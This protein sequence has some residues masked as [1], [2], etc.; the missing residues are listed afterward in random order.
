MY[1][2]SKKTRN[3]LGEKSKQVME[4]SEKIAREV[5]FDYIRDEHILLA[6]A[7][8]D[9]I[10]K[11]AIQKLGGL[12]S[13]D[14][15]NACK[16]LSR[17]INPTAHRKLSKN[18]SLTPRTLKVIEYAAEEALA[19]SRN[20]KI[21]TSD[22]LIGLIREYEGIA[23]KALSHLSNLPTEKLVAKAREAIKEIAEDN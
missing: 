23:G 5:G 1:R 18:T 16:A 12:D 21:R 15:E 10:A 2:M 8:T 11:I 22:L 9:C 13:P 7:K 20:S 19:R 6:I 17:I 4:T 14:I 3:L